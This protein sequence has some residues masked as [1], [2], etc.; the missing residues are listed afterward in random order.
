MSNSNTQTA[1]VTGATGFIGQHLVLQLLQ[2]GFS[3]RALSREKKSDN[4][5][6]TASIEWVVAD[7]TVKKSLKTVCQHIDYVFHLAGY[8]HAWSDDDADF[9][10]KHH[11]VN[12]QGTMNLAEV[13]LAAGV[14]RF[15]YM[16]TIKACADSEKMIDED[17]QES[18]STPYGRAKYDAEQ[19]LL[20]FYAHS[21]M[22]PIILRPA[23]VYGP[24]WKG[25]LSVM[26]KAVE[27]RLFPSPPLTKNIKSMVSVYDLSTAA[28]QAVLMPL[29]K[30][31]IFIVTDGMEYNLRIIYQIMCE[32]LGR[33]VPKYYLPFFIWKCLSKVGDVQQVLTKKRVPFCT[34]GLDKLFGASHY[35]SKYITDELGFTPRYSLADVM[36]D[37]LSIMHS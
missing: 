23:L 9:Q 2:K 30:H 12:Y 37:I 24:G 36:P 20:T 14:K 5:D 29:P 6:S 33:R 17:F 7:V 28:I 15:I 31:R 32:A 21:A 18:A 34:E 3:V 19:Q 13:A 10:S 27:K 16:S 1:L 8:A 25:N 26:L 22:Q 35:Q 4:V 11:E